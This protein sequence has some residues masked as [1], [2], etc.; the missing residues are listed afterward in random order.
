MR[1]VGRTVLLLLLGSAW[2]ACGDD[3]TTPSDG[4]GGTGGAGAGGT[5]AAGGEGGGTAPATCAAKFDLSK[6]DGA[7]WDDR[8]TI[9][10]FT[11]HDGVA[12][13]VHDFAIDVDGSVVAAGRFQG[14]EGRAAPPLM[15]LGEAGWEPARDNWEIEAPLDGFS[16]V[17]ISDTGTLAL[18]TND[19]FGERDGEI[20]IDDGAGLRSIGSFAG[21]VRSLAFYDDKLW[22]AGLFVLD[23]DVPAE[24]LAV[25]AAEA[26]SLAPGG[27]LEGSAFELQVAQGVLYVGGSFQ[28]I[29]GIPAANVASYD[30]QSWSALDFPEA[31]AVY[32]LATTDSGELY[33]GGA[34]GALTS[35]G[36][37][38]RWSGEAWETVGG[39]LSMYQTRGVVTDLVS[40]GETVDATG[41]FSSAGG[42][43]DDPNAT[44]ARGFARW[45]GSAWEA[46]DGGPQ[47]ALT[48]WFQP[49]ACGDESA[50]ALWDVTHQRLAYADD[51]LIAG[52]WFSGVGDVLSQAI[53]VYENDAWQAQGQTGLGLGG[54]L[55]F[56]AVGGDGCDQVYGLGSFSHAAGEPVAARVLRFEQD[57][58]VALPD[59]LPPFQEADT[60]CPTLDVSALGEVAVGCIVST[61]DGDS[62]GAILRRE[63]DALVE[64]AIEGVPPVMQVKWVGDALYVVGSGSSGY[65]ARVDGTTWTVLEDGFDSVV[66]Q[67]QVNDENDLV[68][69]GAFTSIDGAPFSRIAHWDGKAWA[70]LGEGVPGQVLALDRLGSTVYVSSYNEGNGAYLLGKFDGESWRELA[71]G[72][73]GLAL[74]DFYSFNQ[75]VAKD[76]GIVVVGTA[77]TDGGRGAFVYRSGVFESL[78]GGVGA[79]GVSSVGFANDAL[80]VGGVVAQAGEPEPVSSIG[81]A[82][83]GD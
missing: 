5:G 23:G 68:V 22:V 29:G 8:F 41:C 11:G 42:F 81:V 2:A 31:L 26:W 70:P 18:A 37:L 50:S 72:D 46:I 83:F 45:T 55:D 76:E 19:S 28:T 12:P 9:S 40:H 62:R 63:G 73:S 34:Y 3:S 14:F 43:L 48:P 32:A 1:R 6:L 33:A 60:Y 78:A 53:A 38:A 59:S 44:P 79:I 71:G 7:S 49:G 64:L 77:T 10:G 57:H 16:A 4:G 69:A 75:I 74:E 82:R 67:L 30:G 25:W 58:W 13:A 52:G 51:K 47:R 54:S 27:G 17:A 24:G 80:W 15:R 35:L 66:N 36:G 20:W 65:L 39:G 61:E 56:I 21:Q